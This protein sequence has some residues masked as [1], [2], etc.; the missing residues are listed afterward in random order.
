M[1]REM[2]HVIG[3]GPYIIALLVMLVVG[4]A[5]RNPYLS[6]PGHP[7]YRLDPRA[8]FISL[9]QYTLQPVRYA[10]VRAG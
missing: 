4:F 2:I 8:D 1:I 5:L 9:H 7:V 10:R 6:P 3:W